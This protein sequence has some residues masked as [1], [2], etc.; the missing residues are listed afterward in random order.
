MLSATFGL[1]LYLRW[2]QQPR[3]KKWLQQPRTS[4]MS[5]TAEHFSDGTSRPH[6][7]RI[8]TS[9]DDV[10]LMCRWRAGCLACA[11]GAWAERHL[12]P[13]AL[14]QLFRWLQQPRTK[15]WLQQPRTSKRLC[16]PSLYLQ[17]IAATAKDL[18]DK[19]NSRDGTSQP[20]L[21]KLKN[22]LELERA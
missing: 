22:D 1:R 20:L 4:V 14:P 13:S 5:A 6:I 7:D 15:K 10:N 21:K 18:S 2:L 8:A 16:E 17:E 12:R 19:C 9:I 11:S 3:S